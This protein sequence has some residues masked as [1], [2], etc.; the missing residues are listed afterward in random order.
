MLL[1]IASQLF[2]LLASLTQSPTTPLRIGDV[3][4]RMTEQDIAALEQA[5]PP[6]AKPWLLI[7]VRAWGEVVE[8]YLEPTST[9]PAL[10]RGTVISEWIRQ[11]TDS[12]AQV[13]IPG[14]SFD[15]IEGDQDINRPFRVYGRFDDGELV[16]LVQLLRSN[17]PTRGMHS[18]ESWPILSIRRVE[19]DCCDYGRR[20]PSGVEVS[21]R[22]TDV[23][24]QAIKLR[25]APQETP[26]WVSS[27]KDWIIVAIG[28]WDS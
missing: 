13:A 24:G 23:G 2:V 17:P 9:T 6:G 4:R 1:K 26:A 11:R 7:G 14:R 21:L 19:D 3:A 16:S 15:Q 27:S 22:E 8:A 28:T 5:L 10:R 18:I 20:F 25:Q 12:Y